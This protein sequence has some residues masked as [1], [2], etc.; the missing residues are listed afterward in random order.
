ML[1]EALFMKI[2]VVTG[3]SSGIGFATVKALLEAGCKVYVL[4]RKDFSYDGIIHMPVDVTDEG[5]VCEAIASIFKAEGQIDILVNCAGFGISGAVEFTR[6]E[7]AKRQMDVNFFG[8]VNV[9]KA[10]LPFMREAKGG[11]IVNISSVAAVAPIPFQTYYSAS[12]AAINSYSCALA[13]EV[14]P[15]GITVTA[16]M[17]GDIKTGFT[18]ARVKSDAGNDAYAGR[19]A[20][21]VAKMEQDEINGMDADFAGKYICRIA[22]KKKVKPIYSI[23]FVYKFLSRMCMVM[24]CAWRNNLL[25]KLYG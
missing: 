15:F 16:I 2:A 13:N 23:G 12:K 4:S 6:L 20:N 1:G 8:T 21:S 9:T 11:R 24:P 22:L 14:K 18:A 7:D 3:G 5:L 10:V 25:G 17:P 19:I